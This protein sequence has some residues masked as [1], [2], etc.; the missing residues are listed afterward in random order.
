MIQTIENKSVLTINFRTRETT[1]ENKSVFT[2][3]FSYSV[4]NLE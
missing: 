2:I 4:N 1:I 3:N